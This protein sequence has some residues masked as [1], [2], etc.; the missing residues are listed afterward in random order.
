[1]YTEADIPPRIEES[2][3]QFQWT[4]PKL[5]VSTMS[6]QATPGILFTQY[7]SPCQRT[8]LLTQTSMPR[9]HT[10]QNGALNDCPENPLYSNL[11][12]GHKK[13]FT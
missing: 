11:R 12:K 10:A 6:C 7:T 2:Y 9:K 3:S 4:K 1:M 13:L 8:M 5:C